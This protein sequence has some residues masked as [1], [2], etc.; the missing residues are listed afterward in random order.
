MKPFADRRAKDYRD[1]IADV[2]KL[3]RINNGIIQTSDKEF[4]TIMSRRDMLIDHDDSSCNECSIDIIQAQVARE[5]LATGKYEDTIIDFSYN[6]QGVISWQ[7]EVI[8]QLKDAGLSDTLGR[9]IISRGNP[10]YEL[11]RT[12]LDSSPVTC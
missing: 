11:K 2:K 12:I 6:L 4:L 7:T 3:Y 10:C 5:L 9:R 8:K 1:F